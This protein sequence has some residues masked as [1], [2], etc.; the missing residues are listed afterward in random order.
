MLIPFP[1]CAVY[2][3]DVCTGCAVADGLR[4]LGP[5]SLLLLQHERHL[6]HHRHSDGDAS[7]HQPAV[8]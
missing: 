3:G 5:T 7:E 2:R 6:P 1:P 8:C 4:L